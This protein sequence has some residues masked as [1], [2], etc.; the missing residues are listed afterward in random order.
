[1]EI[2]E[3][4]EPLLTE[5]NL[6]EA[7]KRLTEWLIFYNLQKPHQALKYKTPIEWYNDNYK[8]MKVLLMYPIYKN[9]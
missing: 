7:N 4:F 8:L 1:M 2:D 3:Y 6:E 5:S 9:Y